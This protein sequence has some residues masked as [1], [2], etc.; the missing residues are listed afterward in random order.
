MTKGIKRYNLA[1]PKELF[2]ALQ[3]EADKNGTTVVDLIRKFI[4]LGLFAAAVT[5]DDDAELIVRQG[6]SEKQIV[7][8]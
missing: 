3:E 1:L 7:I 5:E 4:K 8:F 2:D 6:D